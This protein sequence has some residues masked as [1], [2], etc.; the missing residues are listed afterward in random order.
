MLG[1]PAL[2]PASMFWL[3]ALSWLVNDIAFAAG[4][5]LRTALLQSKVPNHLQGRVLSLVSTI[6]SLAGIVGLAIATALGE[7][8][9]V[10]WLFVAMG[11]IG[12]TIALLGFLSPAIRA[13]ETRDSAR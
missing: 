10:R 6:L 13:L 7:L 5:A 2:V 8:I 1:L 11:L 12:A 3:G 9:G 4:A